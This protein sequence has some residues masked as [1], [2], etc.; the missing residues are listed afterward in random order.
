MMLLQIRGAMTIL[1]RLSTEPK[2]FA[3]PALPAKGD[4]LA[5]LS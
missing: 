2:P 5:E 4:G 3:D 1:S